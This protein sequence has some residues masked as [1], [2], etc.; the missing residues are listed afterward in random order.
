MNTLECPQIFT[1][2]DSSRKK[3]SPSS[4]GLQTSHCAAKQLS[5]IKGRSIH[6]LSRLP[7]VFESAKPSSHR[8][9]A[10]CS[11]ELFALCHPH[12]KTVSKVSLNFNA[13]VSWVSSFNSKQKKSRE[14]RRSPT[15]TLPTARSSFL[16]FATFWFSILCGCVSS[17]QSIEI[18]ANIQQPAASPSLNKLSPCHRCC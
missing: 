2:Y 6:S 7:S 14:R 11:A 12:H 3:T 8:H 5:H 16:F 18:P 15:E 9:I 13:N 1:V 4:P 10:P 17:S